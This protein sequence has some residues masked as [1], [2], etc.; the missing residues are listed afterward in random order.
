ML[1]S[2]ESNTANKANHKKTGIPER[3]QDENLPVFV[4]DTA[5]LRSIEASVFPFLFLDP[6]LVACAAVIAPM[7]TSSS[8]NETLGFGIVRG[9][10]EALAVAVDSGF[11]ACSMVSA[12]GRAMLGVATSSGDA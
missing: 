3:L 4:I 8:A 12:S 2:K 1:I 9:Q 11:A 7:M 6:A 5:L 10:A